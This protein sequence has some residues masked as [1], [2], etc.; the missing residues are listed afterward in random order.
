MCFESYATKLVL[1]IR[2]IFGAF[3]CNTSTGRLGAFFAYLLYF[4]YFFCRFWIMV[5]LQYN[6]G[7]LADMILLTHCYY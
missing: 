1:H 3:G 4:V 2:L 5:S 6:G 7:F